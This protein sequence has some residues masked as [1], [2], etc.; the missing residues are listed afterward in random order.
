MNFSEVCRAWLQATSGV[1]SSAISEL[2]EEVRSNLDG[3]AVTGTRVPLDVARSMNPSMASEHV[4]KRVN[5]KHV[6]AVES[7]E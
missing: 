5:N 3:V 1:A 4:I 6:K 7:N 2:V